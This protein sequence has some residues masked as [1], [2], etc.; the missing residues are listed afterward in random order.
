MRM[1]EGVRTEGTPRQGRNEGLGGMG[2]RQEPR[3]SLSLL[4]ACDK[5]EEVDQVSPM[6]SSVRRVQRWVAAVPH[7]QGLCSLTLQ[8]FNLTWARSTHSPGPEVSSPGLPCQVVQ[9]VACMRISTTCFPPP[10][11][12]AL[13]TGAPAALADLPGHTSNPGGQHSG[14]GGVV[15]A[16]PGPGRSSQP[17]PPLLRA[18]AA[19][20][21]PLGAHPT[22]LGRRAHSGKC[23]CSSWPQEP[24]LC[25]PGQGPSALCGQPH[26]CCYTGAWESSTSG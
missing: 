1:G 8:A 2:L 19:Q 10:S 24:W 9:L 5:G 26:L 7:L 3:T 20:A 13:G 12:R 11:P 17:A 21:A 22:D 14:L 25:W 18:L 16:E 23:N 15:P 4:W 6:A